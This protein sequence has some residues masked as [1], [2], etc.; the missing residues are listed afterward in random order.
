MTCASWEALQVTHRQPTA[1][2]ALSTLSR[3]CRHDH[4]HTIF[5]GTECAWADGRWTWEDTATLAGE[6]P[7]A[8]VQEWLVVLAAVAG[9]DAGG[10]ADE[11]DGKLF[12][13][14]LRA[15]VKDGEH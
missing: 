2:F 14:N 11:E 12:T 9:E 5:W 3:A 1:T 15:L 7:A 10:E 8:L 4:R 6:Y 13:T